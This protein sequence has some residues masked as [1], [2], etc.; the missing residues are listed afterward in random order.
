MQRVFTVRSRSI[1][2]FTG[3]MVMCSSSLS[4][5]STATVPSSLS[6]NMCAESIPAA[7]S[8]SSSWE[9]RATCCVP[10]RSRI[11]RVRRWLMNWEGPTSRLRPGRTMRASRLL[12]CTYVRRWAERWEE[13]M[14]RR[15]KVGYTLPGQRA[16]TCKSWREGFDKCCHPRSSQ[17]RHYDDEL[18]D[19]C[20]RRGFRKC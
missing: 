2:P 6:T 10:G 9:T 8:P 3:Q 14:G 19:E 18:V 15:E 7:T 11:M 13:E 5:T 4:L 16:R 20:D 12:F 1:A 17:L